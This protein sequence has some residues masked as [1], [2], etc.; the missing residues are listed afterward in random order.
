MSESIAIVVGGGELGQHVAGELAGTGHSIVVVDRN[1][2]NL[3]KVPAGVH[4]TLADPTDPAV[5][6]PT[7]DRVVAEYGPPEIL[8]NT[9]GA[10]WPGDA[11]STTSEQ[12]RTMLDVNLGTALWLSQAVARHM[13]TRGS[14]SIVHVSARPGLVAVEGMAAYAVSK[15]GLTHL[16]RLLDVELRPV[17]IRVNGVAP[18][19]IANEANRSALPKELLV[20]AITPKAVAQIIAFLVGD[21]AAP[22]S[23]AIVPA[24]G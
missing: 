21:A 12:L 10:F 6:G 14:G 13:S 7:I 15:A 1:E 2:E 3:S 24:Y 17:G 8:V 9:V 19:L 11:L 20:H 16:I 4:G 5:V 22:I 18:Q 23:G